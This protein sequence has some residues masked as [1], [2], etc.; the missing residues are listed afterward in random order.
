[1][2]ADNTFISVIS[3][4]I[5]YASLEVAEPYRTQFQTYPH[6]IDTII[7]VFPTKAL[8]KSEIKT[9]N[10]VKV[11]EKKE[12]VSDGKNQYE[13]VIPIYAP[14]PYAL[15]KDVVNTL[16]L[17]H[18]TSEIHSILEESQRLLSQ[19]TNLLSSVS[20][21]NKHPVQRILDTISSR[22]EILIVIALI[23]AFLIALPML[24]TLGAKM[25]ETAKELQK[26]SPKQFP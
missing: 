19:A 8:D 13:I 5:K 22:P 6:L 1:M 4:L 3:E 16:S 10:L 9:L 26:I 15:S 20:P 24:L 11:G 17:V 18:K 2:T 14:K 25:Q 7:V 21:Q 23:I 12:V